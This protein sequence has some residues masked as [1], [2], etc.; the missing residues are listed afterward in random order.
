MSRLVAAAILASS[1]IRIRRDSV[2]RMREKRNV[3]LAPSGDANENDPVGRS[4]LIARVTAA[5]SAGT[6]PSGWPIR[7][8]RSEGAAITVPALST[9]KDMT[10]RRPERSFMI[11]DIQLRLMLATMTRSDSGLTAATG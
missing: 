9:R 3:S 4:G 8:E 10:P 11:F 6:L 5:A 2:P 7:R 1:T